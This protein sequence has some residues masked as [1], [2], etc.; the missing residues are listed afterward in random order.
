MLQSLAIMTNQS[1][2]GETTKEDQLFNSVRVYGRSLQINAS[3][4]LFQIFE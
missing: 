2:D 4:K 1:Q 3:I